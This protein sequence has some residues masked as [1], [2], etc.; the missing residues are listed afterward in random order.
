MSLRFIDD[1][2]ILVFW[3]IIIVKNQLVFSYNSVDMNNRREM[4]SY[5]DST[6]LHHTMMFV[7]HVK[8]NGGMSLL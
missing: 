8:E 3:F 6:R 7:L 5:Y 4:T 2:Y 1:N